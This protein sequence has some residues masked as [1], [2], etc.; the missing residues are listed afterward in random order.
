MSF[1]D[2]T[3]LAERIATGE[4]GAEQALDAAIAR[5]EALNPLVNAVCNPA[6]AQ[7]RDAARAADVL[8]AA[9]RRDPQGLAQLRRAR[10]FL[11]VPSLLKDHRTPARGLPTSMGSRLFGRIDWPQ[12]CELVTRYRQ[13]GF[14]FFARTTVPEMGLSPSTE[15][16]ANGGPTRNPW[17]TAHSAGGSSGGAGAAVAADMVC[18][19]HGSDGAGSIRIPAS[20]CGLFGLKPSRG[21]MPN[22]P[23]DGEG[24]GGLY[25][26]HMLTRSV[27]DSALALDLSAGA[28]VGAAYAAPVAPLP[29]LE[30]VR[31]AIAAR[32]RPL[33]IACS[34]RTPEGEAVH[35]DVERTVREAA[36]L[37]ATLG[38]HVVE[39][40]PPV[41]ALESLQPTLALFTAGAALAV[42]RIEQQRGRP[43]ADD[44]LEPATR[45]AVAVGRALPAS[46]YAEALAQINT[47]TRKV[48]RFMQ[49]DGQP[50]T[51]YDLLLSPV[52]ATPPIALGRIAMSHPDFMEYRLG[53]EGVVRYSPFTALAN[54]TGQPSASVPFGRSQDGLPIGVM[55][56]GR[57]GEDWRVLEVAACIEQARPWPA[58]APP[59][60]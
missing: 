34:W 44:E 20:N 21:L 47:V 31:A 26:Q 57:F 28:D 10:P 45:S 49:G 13:A 50:G 51:G 3:A 22:G 32:P 60:L 55:L 46:R 8:L 5:C 40:A 29:Y 27:R 7:A 25:T 18:I 59:L 23:M 16:V 6:H 39:A 15:A 41:T 58:S 43:A 33:R 17:S 38:H 37:L 19:A 42:D 9:A 54:V 36:Q 35:P 2:A 14:V 53:R 56:T 30:H 4:I 1:P 11:G 52:L 24:G 48:A 12:D